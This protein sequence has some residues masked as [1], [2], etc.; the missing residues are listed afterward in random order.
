MLRCS[1][2]GQINPDGS[3]VCQKCGSALD[4][5]GS[6]RERGIDKAPGIDDLDVDYTAVINENDLDAFERRFMAGVEDW[7]KTKTA[8]MRRRTAESSDKSEMNSVKPEGRNGA[9]RRQS[10]IYRREEETVR[11]DI[12]K[13][14][15]HV[16]AESA[17]RAGGISWTEARRNA[18]KNEKKPEQERTEKSGRLRTE[19]PLRERRSTE[20]HVSG[21]PRT[22]RPVRTDTGETERVEGYTARERNRRTGMQS[23]SDR[24]ESAGYQR[25]RTYGEE[26]ERRSYSKRSVRSG[27]SID[28]SPKKAASTDESERT[29]K[30]ADSTA[31]KKGIFVA[32]AVVVMLIFVLVA[33][34]TNGFTCSSTSRESRIEKSQSDP[35]YYIITV[36]AKEGDVLVFE[37]CLGE[38]KEYTVS[39]KNEVAFN[40]HI[41]SLLPQEPIDSDTLKVTPTVY[42]K[43]KDG[44]LNRIEMPSVTIDVP[45]FA[46]GFDYETEYYKSQQPTENSPVPSIE[47]SA[48]PSGTGSPEPTEPT[49]EPEPTQ[50]IVDEN[51]IE[52]VN[53]KITISGFV[54]DENVCVKFNGTRVEVDANKKF[55][56]STKFITQGEH[57]IEVEATLP[58]YRTLHKTITAVVKEELSPEQIIIFDEGFHTRTSSDSTEIVVKGTVPVGAVIT[59]SSDAEGFTLNGEPTVDEKGYFTFIVNMPEVMTDYALTITASMSDG[60]T[61]QRRVHVQRPP[62]YADYVRS[63][64]ACDYNEM[65][66]PARYNTQ[67]FKLTGVVTEIYEST[68]CVRAALMLPSGDIVVITY[69]NNYT[70]SSE[71]LAGENYTMYGV[72]TG[73]NAD[74]MLEVY[75]WF[76]EDKR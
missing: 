54:S 36:V 5:A 63:V 45:R 15:E 12:S 4:I 49:P 41:S 13:F 32:V 14:G 8:A 33:V 52:C 51:T 55:S 38:R 58:G 35:S 43:T 23:S 9:D 34:V 70:G 73:M 71:I 11:T 65:S 39:S 21:S 10:D 29:E 25:Y 56:F 46:L 19:T 40:A 6:R 37:N 24:E 72:P 66:K 69:Y 75:I 26:G 7:N 20:T 42:L 22:E 62:L 67:G 48:V 16:R 44:R 18:I 30:N 27:K 28:M 53:G 31:V 47:P 50:I 74:N 60:M 76:V 64:W 61:V 3:R 57:L 2:C 17:A 68:D 59:V 1:K